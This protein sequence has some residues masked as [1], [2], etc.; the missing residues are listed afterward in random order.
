MPDATSIVSRARSLRRDMT[1]V[2]RRLWHR[3]RDRRLGG[4]KLVRQMPVG[5]FFADFA[6]RDARLIVELDGSQ[7]ADSS[8]DERRDRFLL[9]QGFRVLRFWNQEV[10]GNLDGV[11]ETMLAAV[12][13]RLEPYDRYKVR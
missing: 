10:S 4:H 9:E 12:E 2:E 8:S 3:L 11:C 5:P 1:D 7:H 6:S 13:G